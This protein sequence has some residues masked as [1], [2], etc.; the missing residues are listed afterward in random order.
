MQQQVAELVDAL[1]AHDARMRALAQKCIQCHEQDALYFSSASCFDNTIRYCSQECGNQHWALVQGKRKGDFG[2]EDETPVKWAPDLVEKYVQLFQV[3]GQNKAFVEILLDHLRPEDVFNYTLTSKAFK[4]YVAESNL[5]WFLFLK[6][7]VP[8]RL[9]IIHARA[10]RSNNVDIEQPYQGIDYTAVGREALRRR[11]DRQRGGGIWG[12]GKDMRDMKF[13]VYVEE[14][15]SWTG[16]TVYPKKMTV[17]SIIRAVRDK[18]EVYDWLPAH[19]HEIASYYAQWEFDRKPISDGTWSSEDFD[20]SGLRLH[21]ADWDAH[22]IT[23]LL[24]FIVG[25][26]SSEQSDDSDAFD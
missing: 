21:D 18:L 3:L 22:Q 23:A 26:S 25:S 5:F 24:S 20:L 2:R 16:R 19:R 14:I 8:W 6:K 15:D 7:Y 13:V 12:E 10:A 4:T 17:A 9:L 11:A 1:R